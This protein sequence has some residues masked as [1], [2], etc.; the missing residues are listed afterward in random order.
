MRRGM[1]ERKCRERLSVPTPPRFAPRVIEG[2][3]RVEARGA[4]IVGI[5]VACAALRAAMARVHTAL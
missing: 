3:E 5:R 4:G 1:L 2:K